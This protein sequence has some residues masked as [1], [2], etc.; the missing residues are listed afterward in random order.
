MP[1]AEPPAGPA[2]ASPVII[3]NDVVKNLVSTDCEVLQYLPPGVVE[4]VRR[5]EWIE[6]TTDNELIRELL[7]T[8]RCLGKQL[9]LVV[10]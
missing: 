5:G 10:R 3:A 9:R 2:P 6:I 4:R 7:Q 1:T 8:A